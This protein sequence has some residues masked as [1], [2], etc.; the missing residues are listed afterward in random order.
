MELKALV[1]AATC[2]ATTTALAATIGRTVTAAVLAA[3]LAACGGGGSPSAP[4]GS[5]PPAATPMATPTPT[6]PVGQV[7]LLGASLPFGQSVPTVPLGTAGQAAP[8]LTFSIA[9]RTFESQ[10]GLL[11][12]VWVRTDSVRCMGTGIARVDFVA[13]EQRDFKTLNVSFQAGN[14]PAPCRLPYTT[15]SVEITLTNSAGQDILSQ[16]FPGSYNFLVP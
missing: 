16:R 14:D 3:G 2:F 12:R 10:T 9:V 8:T 13:G 1:S 15:T 6:P 5:L 7:A 11:V 4:T